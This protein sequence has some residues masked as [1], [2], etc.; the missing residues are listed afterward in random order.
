MVSENKMKYKHKKLN[1]K[2]EGDGMDK[3]QSDKVKERQIKGKI[4]KNIP[5][6]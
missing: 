6:W 2:D 5:F 1:L 4:R 3:R